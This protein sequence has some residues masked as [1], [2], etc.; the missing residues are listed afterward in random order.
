MHILRR[1]LRD[2]P[3]RI[4]GFRPPRGRCIIVTARD[5]VPPSQSRRRN[6]TAR[7][8]LAGLI[9]VDSLLISL[10]YALRILQVLSQVALRPAPRPRYCEGLFNV[11]LRRAALRV[12]VHRCVCVCVSPVLQRRHS[13]AL[14]SPFRVRR[15]ASFSLPGQ[16]RW[17]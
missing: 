7:G 2:R 11:E 17:T 12:Y 1:S 15:I 6:V 8:T 14:S 9:D 5:A 3:G 13:D 10:H 16:R 4:D